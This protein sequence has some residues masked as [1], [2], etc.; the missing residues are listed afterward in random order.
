MLQER[1][2]LLIMAPHSVGILLSTAFGV[3]CL[4]QVLQA[5]VSVLF[6]PGRDVR[7]GTPKL[8]AGGTPWELR[9]ASSVGAPAQGKAQNIS[10]WEKVPRN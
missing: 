2:E 5:P 7:D 6:A 4:A 9:W 8:R 3:A 1:G 10:E